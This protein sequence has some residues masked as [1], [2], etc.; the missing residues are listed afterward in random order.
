MAGG[1]LAGEVASRRIVDQ[2]DDVTVKVHSAV[3]RLWHCAAIRLLTA[4]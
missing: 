3:L 4:L 2:A 1:S